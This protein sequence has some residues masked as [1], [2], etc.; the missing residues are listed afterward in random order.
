MLDA[1]ADAESLYLRRRAELKAEAEHAEDAR[2]DVL[3]K[4]VHLTSLGFREVARKV[5]PNVVNVAN[6]RDP[7]KAE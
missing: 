3:D 7:K 5:L 2:L 1:Q 4:R 6:Y